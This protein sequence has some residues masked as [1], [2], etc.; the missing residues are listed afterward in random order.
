MPP[1]RNDG[2]EDVPDAAAELERELA[3]DADAGRLDE[4][5]LPAAAHRPE[6]RPAPA[7]GAPPGGRA[8][9]R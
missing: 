8:L 5:D 7:A 4:A 6:A 2:P 9:Q 3:W 1:G